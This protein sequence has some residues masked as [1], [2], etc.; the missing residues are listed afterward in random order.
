MHHVVV[1]LTFALL[2]LLV[3]VGAGNVLADEVAGSAMLFIVAA[4]EILFVLFV[5]PMPLVGAFRTFLALMM[6]FV[7]VA[8]RDLLS[9]YRMGSS[10][11]ACVVG[12]RER[13]T[14][15]ARESEGGE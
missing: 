12:R 7:V 1:F 4:I 13:S 9:G 5:L 2:V 11:R 10:R 6:L 15:P 14:G 8:P 3:R